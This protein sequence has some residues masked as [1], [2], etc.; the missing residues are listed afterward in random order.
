[1][2]TESIS[3]KVPFIVLCKD[4][5]L[6][7]IRPANIP[8]K[9]TPEY[10]SIV[11]SAKQYFQRNMENSFAQ[12]MMESQYLIQLWTAHLLLEY[13]NPSHNL[14]QKCINQ[15]IEYS[16]NPLAR[17]IEN[18]EKLWLN[19]YFENQQKEN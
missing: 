19:N 9:Q 12:Y 17:E 16:D 18:E 10:K 13:G 6:K 3:E 14:Q 1:M 4:A 15:I 7:K 11:E 5:Y 8:S 2:E